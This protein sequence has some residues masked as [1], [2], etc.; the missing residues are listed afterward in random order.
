M[1]ELLKEATVTSLLQL[2]TLLQITQVKN[3]P[4][5]YHLPLLRV[6]NIVGL[7]KGVGCGDM[8]LQN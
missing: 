6:I 5:L 8:M 1:L 2:Y 3:G 4:I 7:V